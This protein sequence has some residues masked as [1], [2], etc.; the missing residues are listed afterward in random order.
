MQ[1]K[2]Y[3][4]RIR[5]SIVL[6]HGSQLLRL[7]IL[8]PVLIGIYGISGCSKLH[9]MR[10]RERSEAHQNARVAVEVKQGKRDRLR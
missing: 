5:P 2:S 10:I 3:K 8:K 7:S 9:T 6:F 1:S 4:I